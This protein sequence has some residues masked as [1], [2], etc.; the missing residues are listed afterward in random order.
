MKTLNLKTIKLVLFCIISTSIYGY[1]QQGTIIVNQD[2]KI[3]KLLELKK[4]MNKNGSDRYKVQI[5]SGSR[6]TAESTE[7]DFKSKFE[8]YPTIVE[9]ETPNYKVWAGNFR[10]RLEADRALKEIKQKFPSAFVFQ[11]KK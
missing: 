7:S 5:Y 6:I 2:E 10:N 9:F 11:P 1:A 8:K 4:E 3:T